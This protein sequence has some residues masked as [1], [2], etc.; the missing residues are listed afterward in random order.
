M[1]SFTVDWVKRHVSPNSIGDMMMI[2]AS[3]K[4]AVMAVQTF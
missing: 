1:V 2:V 3:G 4:I